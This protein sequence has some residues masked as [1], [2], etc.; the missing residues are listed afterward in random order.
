MVAFDDEERGLLRPQGSHSLCRNPPRFQIKSSF[1]AWG[2][3]KHAATALLCGDW[4]GI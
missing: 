4:A 1:L 3:D 2:I